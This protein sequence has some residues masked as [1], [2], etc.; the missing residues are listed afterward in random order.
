MNQKNE[1]ILS[2][3]LHFLKTLFPYWFRG[4]FYKNFSL[5][6]YLDIRFGSNQYKF[7]DYS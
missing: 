1:I 7:P 5:P 4:G 3:L 2:F 6:M